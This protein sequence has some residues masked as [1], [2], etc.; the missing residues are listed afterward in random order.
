MDRKPA[1]QLSLFDEKAS[2]GG[3]P[4]YN[5]Y[6]IVPL[7]S[8]LTGSRQALMGHEGPVPS[9]PVREKTPSEFEANLREAIEKHVRAFSFAHRYR[10]G[11]INAEIRR[12]MGKPR[13]E[14]S[15]AELRNCFVYI[16]KGAHDRCLV[17]G[18]GA[19]AQV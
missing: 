1:S 19:Q 17:D 3:D 16:K 10:N 11:R 12:A 2:G 13:A 7:G 8:A 5:P 14:M 4:N 9:A 18:S 6:N 15:L